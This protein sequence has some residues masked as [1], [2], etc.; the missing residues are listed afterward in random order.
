MSVSGYYLFFSLLVMMSCCAL[1]SINLLLKA[2]AVTNITAYQ[3]LG[4]KAMGKIGAAWVCV[5]I[6]VQNMGSMTSYLIIV[7]TS[8]FGDTGL[9]SRCMKLDHLLDE[10]GM[11][12]LFVLLVLFPVG[13]FRKIEMIGYASTIAIFFQFCFVIYAIMEYTK[14]P[15]SHAIAG[16]DP[17]LLPGAKTSHSCKLKPI[18]LSLDT[19]FV[20]PTL[21]T[22]FVCHTGLLPIYHELKDRSLRRMQGVATTAISIAFVAYSLITVFG[23]LTFGS[24][25]D[26]N[27]L[28][29]YSYHDPASYS[30][31]IRIGLV[32]SFSFA[33]PLLLFPVRIMVGKLASFYAPSVLRED[34]QLVNV[35]HFSITAVV[36]GICL[37]FALKLPGIL[38]VFGVTGS[39]SA[40]CLV[41]VMPGLFFLKIMQGQKDPDVAEIARARIYFVVGVLIGVVSL[42]GVVTKLAT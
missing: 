37:F 19:F 20:I 40:V 41:F 5:A 38:V 28:D 18:S 13:C 15:C 31:F 32:T 11:L 34:G 4:E 23:L 6:I 33:V 27:L 35:A 16:S 42:T 7:K 29:S 12:C 10:S 9:V 39:T 1:Y 8:G 25:I 14:F 26:A 17:D 22:S 21:A 3:E 24:L 2:C 30:C 36:L